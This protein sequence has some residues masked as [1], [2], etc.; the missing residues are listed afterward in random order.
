MNIIYVLVQARVRAGTTAPEPDPQPQ[1]WG[2][3]D[4][5]RTGPAYQ[6]GRVVGAQ[7]PAGVPDH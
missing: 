3:D 4:V 2:R 6:S 7:G 1:H 5:W